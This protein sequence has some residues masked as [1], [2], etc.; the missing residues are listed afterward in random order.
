MVNLKNFVVQID[1][2]KVV[3]SI[4][5]DVEVVH[6]LEKIAKQKNVGLSY[7]INQILREYV[8]GRRV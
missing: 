2:M 7:L 4:S 5:L 3:K 1:N 8:S 6:K